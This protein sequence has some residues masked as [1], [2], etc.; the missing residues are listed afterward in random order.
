MKNIE[1]KQAFIRYFKRVTGKT[2]L[3]MK[4]VADLA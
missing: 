1:R 4:E 3:N 2:D